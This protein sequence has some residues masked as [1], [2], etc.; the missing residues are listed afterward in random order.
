MKHDNVFFEFVSASMNPTDGRGTVIVREQEMVLDI[1]SNGGHYLIV[2][3]DRTGFFVGSGDGVKARW[4]SLGAE[5]VGLWI[6]EGDEWFFR[7]H[8]PGT[9]GENAPNAA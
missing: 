4:A 5:F 1:E 9:E 3:N 7:F 2:A 6:E 8:L